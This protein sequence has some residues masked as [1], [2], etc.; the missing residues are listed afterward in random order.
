MVGEPRRCPMDPTH[1]TDDLPM[2]TKHKRSQ[3]LIDP[4]W[5]LGVACA[6]TLMMLGAG[7][8]YMLG[9][10]LLSSER[11]RAAL[12]PG[13]FRWVRT[14]AD[15]VFFAAIAMGVHQVIVRVTHQVV[16]PALVIERGL[17]AL[18]RDDFGERLS[19]R[20]GDYL[21][22]VSQAAQDLRERLAARRENVARIV[23]D[24]RRGQGNEGDLEAALGALESEFGLGAEGAPDA[25]VLAPGGDDRGADEETGR[26]AA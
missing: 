25:E 5:Q 22:T 15:V 1:P 16:G 7:A 12:G 9:A 2:D 14:G 8:L 19:L 23:E 24:L 20:D 13:G 18:A 11:V 21:T 4:R 17:R 26:R 10:E 3:R 6:V